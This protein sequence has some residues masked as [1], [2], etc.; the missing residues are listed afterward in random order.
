MVR[1]RTK[2]CSLSHA[3]FETHCPAINWETFRSTLDNC[4]FTISTNNSS[5]TNGTYK[6]YQGRVHVKWADYNDTTDS[7]LVRP[8]ATTWYDVQIQVQDTANATSSAVNS[9][10]VP[11]N[12]DFQVSS[13]TYSKASSGA[14]TAFIAFSLTTAYPYYA[15]VNGSTAS[16]FLIHSG[17]TYAGL[18]LAGQWSYQA[19]RDGTVKS[20]GNPCSTPGDVCQL[21]GTLKYTWTPAT[22][23]CSLSSTQFYQFDFVLACNSTGVSNSCGAPMRSALALP[24]FGSF[25]LAGNIDFCKAAS[26]DFPISWPAP[27]NVQGGTSRTIGSKIV[28][29]GTLSANKKI[30]GIALKNYRVVRSGLSGEWSLWNAGDTDVP[31]GGS[32]YAGSLTTIGT[33]TGFVFAQPV[34]SNNGFEW[35]LSASFTPNI[36]LYSTSKVIESTTDSGN[37]MVSL[38][39]DKGDTISFVMS[40]DLRLYTDSVSPFARKRRLRWRDARVQSGEPAA[41]RDASASTD[42]VGI[43]VPVNMQVSTDGTV[44]VVKTSTAGLSTGAVAGIAAMGAIVG[45]IGAGLAVFAVRRHQKKAHEGDTEA[46]DKAVAHMLEGE[47]SEEDKKRMSMLLI[48]ATAYSKRSHVIVA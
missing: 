26:T 15:A 14:V 31:F 45:I 39:N 8:A 36:K 9:T 40:I 41:I 2:R 24:S 6:K 3:D 23:S 4:G 25:E 42:P 48:S 33:N 35:A 11:Y 44:T 28:T 47:L 16:D 29:E 18:T 22:G 30:Y 5:P 1:D 43:A 38:P 10:E 13:V 46:A 12:A 32:G 21:S 34:S 17:T 20:D 37:F 19:V 7:G 27:F